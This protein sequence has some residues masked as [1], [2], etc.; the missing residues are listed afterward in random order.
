MNITTMV[1]PVTGQSMGYR[2]EHRYRPDIGYRSKHMNTGEVR[3]WVADQ[4]IDT[5]QSRPEHESGQSIG[6]RSE[7]KYR[8]EHGLQVREWIQIRPRA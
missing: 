3:A 2:S 1:H 6:Y 4:S 5:G 7:H 8:S